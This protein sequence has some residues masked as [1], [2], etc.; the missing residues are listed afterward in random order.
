MKNTRH[1]TMLKVGNGEG[2]LTKFYLGYK[3]GTPALK[4]YKREIKTHQNDTNLQEKA[5]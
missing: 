2:G 1:H 4:P 5:M 3:M